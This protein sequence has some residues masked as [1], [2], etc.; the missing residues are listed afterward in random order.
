ME[1][2]VT[3]TYLDS[4]S[5]GSYLN[6]LLIK[7]IVSVYLLK[8]VTG[9]DDCLVHAKMSKIDSRPNKI[10]TPITCVVAINTEY[11]L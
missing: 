6:M 11:E 7:K 5:S 9:V 4:G 10:I 1:E 3:A 8:A 2:I